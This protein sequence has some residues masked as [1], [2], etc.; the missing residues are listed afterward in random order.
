MTLAG[1]GFAVAFVA[2]VL[3][4]GAFFVFEFVLVAVYFFVVEELEDFV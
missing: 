2:G 3:F 1:A 4:F